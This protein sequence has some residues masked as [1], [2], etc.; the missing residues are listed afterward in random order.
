MRL[1]SLR[2]KD[3]Q[4]T[5]FQ[6]THFSKID[7]LDSS[8]FCSASFSSLAF[9][10]SRAVS[11]CFMRSWWSSLRVMQYSSNG[12]SGREREEGGCSCMAA[13]WLAGS[14]PSHPLPSLPSSPLPS[15]PSLP[16]PAPN[17]YPGFHLALSSHCEK[18]KYFVMIE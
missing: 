8:S 6:C 3:T 1:A 17:N 13:D 4:K 18:G 7:L 12:C 2:N 11:C 5:L 14:L 9:S 10:S 16:V 15:P